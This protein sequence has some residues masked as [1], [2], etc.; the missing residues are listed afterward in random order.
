MIEED[1]E[2]KAINS[3]IRLLRKALTD[4]KVS[5]DERGLLD[6]LT[7]DLHLDR[8]Y[9][10]KLES[11]EYFRFRYLRLGDV[12]PKIKHNIL[13]DV[14]EKDPENPYA[15][16]YKGVL[17]YTEG[18]LEEALEFF[19]KSLDLYP[20]NSLAWYWKAR[21]FIRLGR[22]EDALDCLEEAVEHDP[23]H[24]TSWLLMAQ[25]HKERGNIEKALACIN[26]AIESS[27]STLH[28]YLE[29]G[30]I[31]FAL[32]NLKEAQ[33]DLRRVLQMDAK[34]KDAWELLEKVQ[35]TMESYME[36]E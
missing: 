30:R 34:N 23:E 7:M 22:I 31:H 26:Q 27:P 32:G 15:P 35:E 2:R 12:D 33:R 3:Y 10:K 14:M 18:A 4:G 36:K 21:T 1:E 11:W 20:E 25:T 24:F 28:G 19:Q 9:F 13:N 29:R 8:S 6:Q 16:L 5:L 17:L